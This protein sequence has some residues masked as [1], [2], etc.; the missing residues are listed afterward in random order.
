LSEQPGDGADLVDVTGM[1]LDRIRQLC[2][3]D[4]GPG[5]ENL[6]DRPVLR[7]ALRRILD[8]AR[9]AD[10]SFAGFNDTSTD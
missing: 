8:D 7:R 9:R 4:S 6:T 1:T 10:E 5:A 2:D 3:P